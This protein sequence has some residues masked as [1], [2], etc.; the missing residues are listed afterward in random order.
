VILAPHGYPRGHP[1][2]VGIGMRY[3]VVWTSSNRVV[4]V[5]GGLGL[6]AAAGGLG[7]APAAGGLG[8]PPKPAG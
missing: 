3:T 4:A 5:A 1:V 8:N 2:S 7:L 6:A